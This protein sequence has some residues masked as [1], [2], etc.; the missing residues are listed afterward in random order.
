MQVTVCPAIAVGAEELDLLPIIATSYD[1]DMI[2]NNDK[3]RSVHH[4]L[5]MFL[6]DLPLWLVTQPGKRSLSAK[7]GVA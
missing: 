7:R 5:T 2:I 6:T 4:R 1:A 3:L